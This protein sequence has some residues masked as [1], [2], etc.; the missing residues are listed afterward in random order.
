MAVRRPPLVR[1]E[2]RAHPWLLSPT[3]AALLA[4]LTEG[5]A[6][7]RGLSLADLVDRFADESLLSWGDDVPPEAVRYGIE[8]G[9][10]VRVRR[11]PARLPV[12]RVDLV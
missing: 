2:V 9:A 8:P 11:A 4:A 1:S 3:E 10:P 12:E 7:G 5:A 6:F